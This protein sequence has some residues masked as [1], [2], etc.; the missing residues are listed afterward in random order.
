MG[1]PWHLC[2]KHVNAERV[3]IQSSNYTNRRKL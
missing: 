2:R 3:I 1:E